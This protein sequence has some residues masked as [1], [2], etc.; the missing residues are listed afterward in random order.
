VAEE[1]SAKKVARLEREIEGLKEIEALKAENERLRRAL[2]EALRVGKRQAE[3][4]SRREPKV[5]PQKPGRKAGKKY[6]RRCRRPLPEQVDEIVEVLLPTSR[7]LASRAPANSACCTSWDLDFVA[8]KFPHNQL[9]QNL[10]RGPAYTATPGLVHWNEDEHRATSD[11]PI[12]TADKYIQLAEAFKYEPVSHLDVSIDASALYLLSAP[13]VPGEVREE[14]CR[15][16]LVLSQ[17][18]ASANNC[19]AANRSHTCAK[20]SE[21]AGLRHTHRITGAACGLSTAA[22]TT[23]LAGIG[24]SRNFG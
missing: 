24:V 12:R 22:F 6:G 18:L 13:T 17:P 2:E 8:S 7:R 20:Q 21:T 23:L 16:V 3:P 10:Q 4:F 5:H 15:P 11:G 14:V 1:N 19:Q 9:F